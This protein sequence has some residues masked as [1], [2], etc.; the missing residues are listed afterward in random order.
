MT[1]VAAVRLAPEVLKA[2]ATVPFAIGMLV[3]AVGLV[4]TLTRRRDAAGQLAASLALGLE[5]LLASGLIRLAALQS[6]EAF[7]LVAIIVIL[8]RVIGVG[9]AFAVA[10]LQGRQPGRIR[11]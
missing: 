1:L 6:L 8:R 11:A 3:I 4:R 2:V 9:L 10:A 5:F 7:G